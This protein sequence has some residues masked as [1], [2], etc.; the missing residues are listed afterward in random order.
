VLASE[1]S[2][3]PNR[4]SL[5]VTPPF[6]SPSRL[7]ALPES[8]DVYPCAANSTRQRVSSSP[9]RLRTLH[10]PLLVL[11]P[12]SAPRII[13]LAP[14]TVRRPPLSPRNRPFPILSQDPPH[15]AP[16]FLQPKI[17]G[18]P[19]HCQPTRRLEKPLFYVAH[20]AHGPLQVGPESGPHR[21]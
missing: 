20:I 14:Q 8:R 16:Q 12:S 15:I 10:H 6:A 21:C 1:M 18:S 17:H 11:S 19:R 13:R 9:S 5:S 3:A 4:L 7:C 2:T